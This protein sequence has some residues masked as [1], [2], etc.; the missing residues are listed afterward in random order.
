[1]KKKDIATFIE[2]MEAI[3][4]KWTPEQVEDVYGASSLDEALADRKVSLGTFFD[5][6]GKAISRD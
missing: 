3:G 1:M 5:I 4:D 2:E 6:I